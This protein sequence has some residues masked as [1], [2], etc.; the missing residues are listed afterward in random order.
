VHRNTPTG[1]RKHTQFIRE[2]QVLGIHE[3]VAVVRHPL[4]IHGDEVDV[5]PAAVLEV[6]LLVPALLGRRLGLARRL[7]KDEA[8]RLAVDDGQLL[9]AAVVDGLDARLAAVDRARL[10]GR[11]VLLAEILEQGRLGGPV[12][13]QHRLPCHL[14]VLYVVADEVDVLHRVLLVDVWRVLGTAAAGRG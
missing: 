3:P 11:P 13:L 12:F 9:A 5:E 2:R 1:G 10:L 14:P 7:V 6:L 8:Q 4:R